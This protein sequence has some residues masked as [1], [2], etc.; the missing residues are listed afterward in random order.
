MVKRAN[1]QLE[2]IA[3]DNA[4]YQEYLDG[5]AAEE[6]RQFLEKNQERVGGLEQRREDLAMK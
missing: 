1:A 2:R 4:T 6:T 3:D 5:V